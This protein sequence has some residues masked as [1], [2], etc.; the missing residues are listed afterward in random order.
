M[1]ETRSFSS[2]PEFMRQH[3]TMIRRDRNHPSIIIYSM[4]NEEKVQNG[5]QGERMMQSIRRLVKRLDP[6]RPITTGNND[7]EGWGKAAAKHLDLQGCNYRTH[8]FDW[9]HKTYPD[10][11]LIGTENS[12]R[13]ATRGIYKHDPERGYVDSYDRPDDFYINR[14]PTE[15]MWRTIMER[16]FVMGAFIWT[17]IDYK[18]EPK[19]YGWPTVASNFGLLDSCCFPKD[20]VYYYKSWWNDDDNGVHIFP[21][22]NLDGREGELIDVWC[23]SRCDSVELIVNGESSGTRTMPKMGHV[24]W[25]V[26]YQP[27]YV[28]AHAYRDGKVIGT[29]RIETTGKPK[30]IVLETEHSTIW[31]NGEDIAVVNISIVDQKGRLV[32]TACNFLEFEISENARI[33]GVGNGDP[34]CHEPDKATSRS[35]F[36]GLCQVIVQSTES[37]GEIVLHAKS[38]GLKTAS[39]TIKARKGRVRKSIT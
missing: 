28:E 27:G 11:P 31:A 13:P 32:P 5:P 33:I 17:G 37:A 12:L 16:D 18:G 26:P 1:S 9:F 29:H 36:N 21:H 19:P 7:W 2:G 30:E 8:K 10:K 23:Y 20:T 38:K 15:E 4:A 22:W 3:E 25:Q 14:I 6:T 39:L 24:S 34:S 35:A